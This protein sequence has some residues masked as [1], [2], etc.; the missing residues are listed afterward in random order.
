MRIKPEAIIEGV[1]LI[2]AL[3]RAI[4]GLE[5]TV[6]IASDNPGMQPKRLPECVGKTDEEI[7]A[8][9]REL[10]GVD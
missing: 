2:T 4:H 1:K 8:W 10:L 7:D 3:I 6:R 5:E 9:W